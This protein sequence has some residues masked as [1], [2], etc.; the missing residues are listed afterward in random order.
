MIKYKIKH[1]IVNC[2]KIECDVTWSLPPSPCHKLSHFLRPPSLGAWHTLWTAPFM[3]VPSRHISMS[4]TSRYISTSVISRHISRSVISRQISMSVELSQHISVNHESTHFY[5]SYNE[6]T[7]FLVPLK[8]LG[9]LNRRTKRFVCS[10]IDFIEVN[11][12]RALRKWKYNIH[13]FILSIII[14]QILQNLNK[15]NDPIIRG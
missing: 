2:E 11:V 4:V 7:H 5:V 14:S 13:H 1:K 15:T 12:W 3:S 10:S 9:Y 6:S 8:Q